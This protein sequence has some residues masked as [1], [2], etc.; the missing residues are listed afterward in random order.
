MEFTVNTKE[1]AK[2]LEITPRR[3]QQLVKKGVLH[4]EVD[5]TLNA[6]D[7]IEAYYKW[8]IQETGYSPTKTGDREEFKRE[9]ARLEKA[10]KEMAELRLGILNGTLVYADDVEAEIVKRILVFR[11]RMLVLPSKLS[12]RIASSKNLAEIQAMI[13]WEILHAIDTLDPEKGECNAATD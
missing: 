11:S 8:K 12:P 2:I 1:L 5:G 9:H 7:A 6:H 10:K 3:V 13:Q 4:R